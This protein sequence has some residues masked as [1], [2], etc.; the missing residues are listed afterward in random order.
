M[1]K[2]CSFTIP[3]FK[4]T[5]TSFIKSVDS[6]LNPYGFLK[7]NILVFSI[8]PIW[9]Y[10]QD[11]ILTTTIYN[12]Y[13]AGRRIINE[14]IIE[15][16]L[17]DSLKGYAYGGYFAGT[18]LFLIIKETDSFF[19]I[20]QGERGKGILNTYKFDLTDKPLSSLF[21]WTKHDEI[22]YD[23]QSSEYSSI[24]F[25][26]VLYNN[27]HNKKIEFNTSTMRT[28]KNA[29]KSKKLRKTLPFT[30]EQHLLIFKLL[31]LI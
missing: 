21:S 26:F 27:N 6:V 5:L 18:S 12:E 22:V 25:Y 20:Y 14:I 10:G 16:H 7:F 2:N 9:L 19:K 30:K 13:E 1:H 31:K 17:E 29:Q 24:Y 28:Y 15:N 4:D 3:S 11:N 23:V 8:V